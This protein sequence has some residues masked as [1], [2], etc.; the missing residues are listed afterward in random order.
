MRAYIVTSDRFQYTKVIPAFLCRRR[1]HV[2]VM[3]DVHKI[4]DNIGDTWEP[5]KIFKQKEDAINVADDYDDYLKRSDGA[6]YMPAVLEVEV[7]YNAALTPGCLFLGD[8]YGGGTKLKVYF[9]EINFSDI[10]VYYSVIL[11][12]KEVIVDDPVE[13]SCTII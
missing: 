2:D 7:S 1:S 10:M 3:P 12:E 8:K 5:I 6:G 13:I 11:N 9:D 4:I